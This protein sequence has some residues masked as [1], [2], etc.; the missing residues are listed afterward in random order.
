LTSS[1]ILKKIFVLDSNILLHDSTSIFNFDEHIVVIPQTVLEELDTKKHESGEIGFA[2]RQFSR[3]VDVLRKKGNLIDGVELNDKG[4]TFFITLF[5]N[6]VASCLLFQDMNIM[7]NR[8]L[9]SAKYL[10]TYGNIGGNYREIILVSKDVNMRIKCDVYGVKAEDYETDK[11]I[12]DEN[13]SGVQ[14]ITVPQHYIDKVYNVKHLEELE[15]EEYIFNTQPNECFVLHADSNTKQSALVRYNSIM[16][17]F[18]LLPPDSKTVDIQ[19]RN[20][21]QQFALDILKDVDINLVTMIG[22]AGSGKTLMALAAGLYG[23]LETQRYNKILLL[24][25]IVAMDNGHELGF[26]PGSMEEKLGPWM[27]SYADNIE[28]IM[29]NYIKEENPKAKKTKKESQVYEEKAAAKTNPIQELMALGLLEM[30]SLEHFRG[31]SLNNQ[32]I[33]LDEAQNCSKNAIKTIITRAGEGTKIILM[34]DI[35]QCD[36]PYLDSKS[37]G[38]SLVV[39]A[40]K[41][42]DIAGHITLKKSERSKLAEIAT[43][44][45]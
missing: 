37:N 19:P 43:E 26:L 8:I 39:D 3:N 11:V 1:P 44:I 34:G 22:K 12:V 36:N 42:Q 5:D 16:R 2:A 28:L 32:Y 23:V 20:T 35:F 30:G 27:A 17:E 13:Y 33:I 40:F 29:Q 9:A 15:L 45:L 38:L 18:R 14:Q 7:D 6:A 31:R 21:E 4:G 24:K 25:P 41:T 10:Q